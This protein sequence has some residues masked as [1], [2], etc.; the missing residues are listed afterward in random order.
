MSEEKEVTSVQELAPIYQKLCAQL[1]E[2][3]F[4]ELVAKAEQDQIAK[5]L[6]D[7]HKKANEL[8]AKK[9]EIEEAVAKA[10]E[11]EAAQKEPEVKVFK[12]EIVS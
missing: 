10:K 6:S 3:R 5:Q 4:K 9:K 2:S 7:L 11:L 12:P 1:G 8:E